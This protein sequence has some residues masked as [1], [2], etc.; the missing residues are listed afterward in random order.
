MAT[1]AS[2]RYQ[3]V[4]LPPPDDVVCPICLDIVVEPHLLTCC[5]QH[6][7]KGCS[8]DLIGSPCPLCRDISHQIVPDRY[9]ERNILNCL[10]VCCEKFEE[11]CKWEGELGARAKHMATCPC[12]EENCPYQ[13]DAKCMRK[14]LNIHKLL[15]QRRPHQCWYC[16]YESTYADV[17]KVHLPLCDK[18]P[19]LCPNECAGETTIT[20]EALPN[21]IE[22]ECPLQMVPC[23]FSNVCHVTMPRKDLPQHLTEYAQHHTALM[24]KEVK[25][26][27]LKMLQDKD[28]QLEEKNQLLYAKDNII[29]ERN[30]QLKEKDHQMKEKDRQMKEKDRQMK[31][32]D[33]QLQDKDQQLYAKDRRIDQQLMEK[34]LQMKQQLI[35]KDQQLN[36]KDRII[37][38]KD[39]QLKEKDQQLSAK[40]RRIE[41]KDKQLQE[42]LL[43]SLMVSN[44]DINIEMSGF[45][46]KKKKEVRWFSPPY[47][48]HGYKMCFEVDLENNHDGFDRYL[49]IDHYIMKGPFDD[50]LQ[51]PFRG[52]VTVQVVNQSGVG[53]YSYEYDYSKAIKQGNRVDDDDKAIEYG[54]ISRDLLFSQL[55]ARGTYLYIVNDTIKFKILYNPYFV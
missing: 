7:C 27:L 17:T 28:R 4:T 10:P 18:A 43:Y 38:E 55:H 13:C 33:Q 21:H 36:A 54:T 53:N 32:K 34:D 23:E 5:G 35:Y 9:F 20:R 24:T 49:R 42:K 29:E 26:E 11:G 16:G 44:N 19:V 31:E 48:L 39:K 30:R 12:V 50:I 52:K 46:E 40:D 47:Y 45:S 8:K 22:K 51:W 3:L 41:E 37:A 1:K 6:L 2:Y 15:C 25:D 14:S